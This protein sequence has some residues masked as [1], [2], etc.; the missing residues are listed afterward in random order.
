[1]QIF[2]APR[3]NETSYQNFQS[4]IANGIEYSQV[5]P[6]LNQ[7]GKSLLKD[8]GKLY[9]WGCKETKKSSWEK[10][11]SGDLV[12]FYKG[13]EQDEVEGKFIHVVNNPRHDVPQCLEPV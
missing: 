9:V 12:L 8:V 4:T 10:M 11:E 5:E 13:R 3:S 2:L 7:D 1:M 6:Y